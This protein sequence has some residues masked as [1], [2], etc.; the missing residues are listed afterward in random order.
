MLHLGS[1]KGRHWTEV[2][3]LAYR[4]HQCRLLLHLHSGGGDLKG[5]F[6][7]KVRHS[8][9]AGET[10]KPGIQFFKICYYFN[11]NKDIL[12]YVQGKYSIHNW[13]E[14]IYFAVSESYV[15]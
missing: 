6:K 12:Y 4:C 10:E 8:T 5:G 15:S 7:R 3:S 9:E 13:R 11:N 2:A 1:S 14:L